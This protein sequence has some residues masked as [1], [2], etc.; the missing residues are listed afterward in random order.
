MTRLAE[1]EAEV[2]RRPRVGT[3]AWLRRFHRRPV[4]VRQGR[5]RWIAEQPVSLVFVPEAPEW[6]EVA[7]F[8][9]RVVARASLMI[10]TGV[11]LRRLFEQFLDSKIFIEAIVNREWDDEIRNVQIDVEHRDNMGGKS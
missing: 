9:V 8:E 11:W 1:M 3:L 5:R 4:L 7:W 6:L 2:R 10:T